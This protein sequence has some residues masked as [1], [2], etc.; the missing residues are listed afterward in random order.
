MCQG[1]GGEAGSN[2]SHLNPG[3][4]GMCQS[5]VQAQRR[6]EEGGIHIISREMDPT[7]GRLIFD[8]LRERGDGRLVLLIVP[9]IEEVVD[10]V[11]EDKLLLSFSEI[12]KV[13]NCSLQRLASLAGNRR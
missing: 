4:L 7:K 1:W 5:H 12:S 11:L 6:V 9:A 3:N 10:R 2:Q 8:V 13:D